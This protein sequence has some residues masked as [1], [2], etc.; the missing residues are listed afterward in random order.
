MYTDFC[1]DTE[2]D[3]VY[4][5]I[6]GRTLKDLYLENGAGPLDIGRS[7]PFPASLTQSGYTSSTVDKF[8]L[9]SYYEAYSL[10]LTNTG[11]QG[12]GA[13]DERVWPSGSANHY[14]LRSPYSSLPDAAVNVHSTG[15]LFDSAYAYVEFG[16]SAARA[17]FT[18]PL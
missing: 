6:T 4:K 2:N 9:L 7:V 12:T 15:N 16:G 13:S 10:F 14:W 5:A 17:A 11:S 3:I 8:W 18:M 1:I